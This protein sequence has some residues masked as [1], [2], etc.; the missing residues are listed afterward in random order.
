MFYIYI[1]QHIIH[2][3]GDNKLKNTLQFLLDS[4]NITKSQ[5]ARDL[6]VTR[7]TIIRVVKGNTPSMSLAL[8][9]AKY[10]EKDV[11]DIFFNPDVKHVA[12]KRKGVS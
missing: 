1:V 8:K 10:F 12:Q 5:L 2:R 7:Q 4:N 3:K 11:S 9:I 6:G